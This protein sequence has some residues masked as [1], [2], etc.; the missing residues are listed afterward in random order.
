MEQNFIDVKV[1]DITVKYRPRQNDGDLTSLQESIERVGLLCPITIDADNVLI[2][3][4][5]HLAACRNLGKERISA[6][7]LGIRANSLR[8][9]DVQSDENLCRLP[10]SS[11][12]LSAHIDRKKKFAARGG[13]DRGLRRIFSGLGRLFRR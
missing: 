10:L 9:L 11:A 4:A 7:R 13:D 1:D 3:G 8:G 12:E 2:A 6:C 5:R